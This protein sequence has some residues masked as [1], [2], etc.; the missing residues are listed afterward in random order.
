MFI[1]W[2]PIRGTG[3]KCLTADLAVILQASHYRSFTKW[4]SK[5]T[6]QITQK[7]VKMIRCRYVC[8]HI[9]CRRNH[10]SSFSLSQ[11]VSNPASRCSCENFKAT[12]WNPLLQSDY[13]SVSSSA[14]FTNKHRLKYQGT[15]STSEFF[16]FFFR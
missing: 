3:N 11:N 12:H 2:F 9:I 13:D 1:I 15:K 7:L 14:S 8:Y 4:Y 5:E 10:S 16:F 6:R